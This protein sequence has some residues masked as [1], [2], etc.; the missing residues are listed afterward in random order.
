MRQSFLFSFI[1]QM[2]RVVSIYKAMVPGYKDDDIGKFIINN[3]PV[4]MFK[5]A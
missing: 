2:G 3:L 5:S 1:W 4:D